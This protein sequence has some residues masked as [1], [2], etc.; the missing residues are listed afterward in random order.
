MSVFARL[1]RTAPSPGV[2]IELAADRVSAAR[3]ERRG[4]PAIVAHAVV[5][6]PEGALVPSLQESNLR[7]RAAIVAALE[8]ALDRVG[9]PRRVGLVVPDS[10]AKVSLVRLT[11]MPDRP[12]DLDQ[13]IHWQVRKSAPFRIEDAQV[14]WVPGAE[15]P[16]GREF[17]TT[18]AKRE[19]VQEYE[20]LCAQVG[21]HAGIVDISTFNLANAVLSGPRAPSGDWL[22]VNTATG[23]VSIAVL[24]GPY[25][26]F[27][28]SRSAEADD[29]L[30]DLV[31]QSAMYYEDRLHGQGFERIVLSGADADDGLSG[32]AAEVRRGLEARLRVAV[33]TLDGRY[34]TPLSGGSAAAQRHAIA[35]LVGLLLRGTEAA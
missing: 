21:A 15:S 30:A 1:L 10:I 19:I 17:V 9:R 32:S 24:H 31:H 11:Q 22:L 3:I 34:V 35:P 13:L 2:A 18:V 20:S 27:F 12:A 28:R 6:L 25:L 29:T 8:R 16:D 7:D 5:P 26:R 33:E 14:S 4:N 23:Y